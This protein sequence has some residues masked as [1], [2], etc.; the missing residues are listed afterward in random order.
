MSPLL[1]SVLAACVAALVGW[2]AVWLAAR[3]WSREQGLLHL[4]GGSPEPAPGFPPLLGTWQVW[5]VPDEGARR[6]VVAGLLAWAVGHRPTLLAPTPSNRG[7]HQDRWGGRRGGIW[8]DEPRP[9]PAGLLDAAGFVRSLGAPIVILEGPGA[10]EERGAEER[11]EDVLVELRDL[12][13]GELTVVVLLLPGEAP[14]LSVDLHLQPVAEGVGLQAGPLVFAPS[15]GA[16]P[17]P[18]VS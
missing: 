1:L 2:F 16:K 8:L 13:P 14:T 11:E 7:F 12:R 5:R 9:S 3:F 6:E 4:S 15:G 18:G 10:L 17:A